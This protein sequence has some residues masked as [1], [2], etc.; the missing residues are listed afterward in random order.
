MVLTNSDY[1]LGAYIFFLVPSMLIGF[2]FARRRLFVPHHKL[3]MTVIMIINWGLILWLMANTYH[4]NI[5]PELPG[6]LTKAR[7]LVTTIHATFGSIAQVFATYLVLRMWFENQ[8]PAWIKVK[9]I[10]R[11]M[12]FTLSMWLLTALFGLG[13][14]FTFYREYRAN[15]ATSATPAA[16]VEATA[17]ATTAAT[18]AATANAAGPATPAATPAETQ[19]STAA[20]TPGATQESTPAATDAA[21]LTATAQPATQQATKQATASK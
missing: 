17:E 15:A 12:R 11:Y 8:L 4:Q 2:G 21:T 16:T 19:E 10:K 6:G 5:A 9:N 18:G 20:A 13:V 3:T 1:V 7:V 14:W